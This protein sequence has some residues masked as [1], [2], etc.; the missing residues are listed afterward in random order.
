[1]TLEDLSHKLNLAVGMI[2]EKG[3]EYAD[4]KA[5]YN[6]LY[7]L[8]KVVLASS[9]KNSEGKTNAEKEMLG[10]T[11]PV[12][13][14]HLETLKDAE[15]DY[16]RAEA[17]YKRWEAEADAARTLISIEKEKIRNFGG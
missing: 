7:E 16:L 2:E 12:Y 4:A 3:K 15:G 11:S 1:M 5:L 13:Q 9:A 8:K 17:E 10:L 14:Q 6:Y